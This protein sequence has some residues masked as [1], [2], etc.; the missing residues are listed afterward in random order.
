MA[1]RSADLVLSMNAGSPTALAGNAVTYNLTV[2]NNGDDPANGINVSESFPSFPALNPFSFTASQGSYD[3]S[4]GFWHLVSLGKGN[5]ATLSL[6][7]T[8]PNIAGDL[9]E[10]ATA[11]SSNNDPNSSN[12]TAT[13]T[14]T[15]LSPAN[16]SGTK[17]VSG[18]LTPGSTVT[19]T[20]VLSNSSSN[21]QQNNSGNEFT[22]VLPSGLTLVSANATSGTAVATI[23]TNTVTWDGKIAAG[24]SV[25]I[26]ILATVKLN[27]GNQL[28]SNQGSISY[29]ADG[30]GVNEASAVTDNPA[31]GAA[32]DATVFSVV[33]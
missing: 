20:V 33:K 28:I 30:N 6:N 14:T 18:A 9:T 22:D 23:A 13:A 4:T 19:Y 26:T 10:Q 8:A 5:S 11:S 27:T 29:D 7:V 21:D 31:T 1:P 3:P 17:T 12:N 16:V 32:N 2:T 24:G 15:V 25:T